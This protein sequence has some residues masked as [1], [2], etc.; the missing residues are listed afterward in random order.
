KMQSFRQPSLLLL[1]PSSHWSLPLT[2]PSPQ[3]VQPGF[4]QVPVRH[5]P[6]E[7]G[8]LAGEAV[9]AHYSA[10]A[11]GGWMMLFAHTGKTQSFR[12]PSV[13]MLPPSSHCSPPLTMP[14]P[15]NVQPSTPQ[16]PLVRQAPWELG[17]F[18]GKAVPS[19]F[20][21]QAAVWSMMLSPHTGKMQSFRQPSLL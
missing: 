4:P 9:P 3:N 12:R 17:A 21:T 1:L 16:A 14:S 19:H 6:C 18:A 2:M 13:S 7:E 5:A 20:S 10:Q 8:A 15:Q 11:A